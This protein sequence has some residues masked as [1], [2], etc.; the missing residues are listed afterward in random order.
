MNLLGVHSDMTLN[1][2]RLSC[3]NFVCDNVIRCTPSLALQIFYKHK[4]SK[5]FSTSEGI[6][7][8]YIQTWH[9]ILADCLVKTLHVT[10]SF[11][12]HQVLALQKF[13]KQKVSNDFSTSKG[14]CLEYIQTWHWILADCLVKTLH[15]TMSSVVHQVLVLHN[16]YLHQ[17]TLAKLGNTNVAKYSV[18]HYNTYYGFG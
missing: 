17:L 15:V 5:D 14:I 12:V 4:V 16:V 10:M 2:G 7:L 6:C 18:N 13:Y 3:K 1:H 8:E 11:D 9:W